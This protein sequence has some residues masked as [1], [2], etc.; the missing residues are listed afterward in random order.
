VPYSKERL[1]VDFMTFHLRAY[2]AELFERVGGV[3]TSR[4]TS[5]DYDFCLK[6]S[7]VATIVHLREPLYYYRRSTG[8]ISTARRVEQIENSAQAVRD[9]LTRRGLA[10]S[11]RL[12][13]EI[14]GRFALRP[15]VQQARP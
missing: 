7:E 10:E 13:V 5:Y 4:S 3:N 8:G 2:R 15:V 11:L 1:L 12:D 14:V 9:A 6:V